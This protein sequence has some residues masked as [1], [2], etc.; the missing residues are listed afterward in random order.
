MGFYD[1]WAM[2]IDNMLLVRKTVAIKCYRD[3]D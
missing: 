1:T 3:D 2:S